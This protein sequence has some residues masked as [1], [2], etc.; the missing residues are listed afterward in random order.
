MVWF[1]DSGGSTWYVGVCC[2]P[3]R[4][5]TPLCIH[6]SNVTVGVSTLRLCFFA[7]L[8]IECVHAL[9]FQCAVSESRSVV[10]NIVGS[11]TSVPVSGNTSVDDGVLAVRLIAVLVLRGSSSLMVVPTI[12][13]IGVSKD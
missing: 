2:L 12:S 10:Y 4:Y 6:R 5:S 7:P 9:G 1:G 8:G 11:S 13:S 3:P